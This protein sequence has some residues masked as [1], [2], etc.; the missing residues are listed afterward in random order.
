MR[1][2][3]A[4]NIGEGIDMKAQLCFG[5]PDSLL[6]ISNG[7]VLEDTAYT[8]GGMHTRLYA[9]ERLR[10]EGYQRTSEWVRDPWGFVTA[11]LQEVSHGDEHG[12]PGADALRCL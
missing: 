1:T 5:W 12:V 6:I 3:H 7:N 10:Q 4:S 11:E 8:L 2:L 9:D